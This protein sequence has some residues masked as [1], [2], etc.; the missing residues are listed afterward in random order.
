MFAGEWIGSGN[1]S[2]DGL[3]HQADLQHASQVVD[4]FSGG[5][6]FEFAPLLNGAAVQ[7]HLDLEDDRVKGFGCVRTQLLH[8]LHAIDIALPDCRTD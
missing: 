1:Q 4:A 5:P 6:Q 2:G 8:D 3:L 7:R